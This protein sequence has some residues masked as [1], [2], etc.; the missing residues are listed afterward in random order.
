MNRFALNDDDPPLP[1]PPLKYTPQLTIPIPNTPSYKKNTVVPDSPSIPLPPPLDTPPNEVKKNQVKPYAPPPPSILPQ[2][3]PSPVSLVPKSM[4]MCRRQKP[5]HSYDT[6]R[7]PVVECAY[8]TML[9]MCW[10]CFPM[11]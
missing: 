2:H 11:R 8:G 1:P 6:P 4:T 7:N 10:C 3:I 9:C 5:D